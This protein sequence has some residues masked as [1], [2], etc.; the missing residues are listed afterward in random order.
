V[1][2]QLNAGLIGTP[3]ENEAVKTRMTRSF[4]AIPGQHCDLPR[5][6]YRLENISGATGTPVQAFDPHHGLGRPLVLLILHRSG[7]AD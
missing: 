4:D 7:S 1:Y 5:D 6:Q 2:G 3:R